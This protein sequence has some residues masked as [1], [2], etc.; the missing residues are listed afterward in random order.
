MNVRKLYKKSALRAILVSG[1]FFGLTSGAMPILA[2][3]DSI[4]QTAESYYANPAQAA[5]AAQLAEQFTTNDPG[6]QDALQDVDDAQTTVDELQAEIKADDFESEDEKSAAIA[7]LAVAQQE[8]ESA[9]IAYAG[10]VAEVSGV[11]A[12]NIQSI[13][14]IVSHPP[15]IK[16]A[17]SH[18]RNFVPEKG[19]SYP[20]AGGRQPQRG[21]Q[22]RSGRLQPDRV[23][24]EIL[25][26]GR[27]AQ[28]HRRGAFR[29]PAFAHPID[30]G[31]VA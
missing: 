2:A 8:L 22:L 28:T 1:L 24:Q 5:H 20:L 25:A 3:D 13:W 7:E 29:R 27:V 26:G 15:R 18:E 11:T 31:R 14:H 17:E 4:D 19:H 12:A 23:P 16:I 21:G 6:I 30:R 9:E 10:L